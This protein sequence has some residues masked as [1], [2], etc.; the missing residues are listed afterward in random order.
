M[1]HK[2]I[3]LETMSE[4]NHEF[5]NSVSSL[6]SIFGPDGGSIYRTS[7]SSM[8]DTS[9]SEEVESDE[10]QVRVDIVNTNNIHNDD[11]TMD[12]IEQMVDNDEILPIS[13]DP[14]VQMILCRLFMKLIKQV[15]IYGL[16][17]TISPHLSHL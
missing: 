9:E 5:V 2:K 6:S 4:I 16:I 11:D 13:D 14:N 17:A 7:D 12:I 1:S 10:E 3:R 15:K 8:D